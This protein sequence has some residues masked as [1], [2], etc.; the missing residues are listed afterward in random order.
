MLELLKSAVMHLQGMWRYR[1]LGMAVL[2]GITL[3]GAAAVMLLPST[4]KSEARIY[5]DSES[6]LRPLLSGLA[7]GTDVGSELSLV[8]RALISRPNLESVARKTD[9]YLRAQNEL[10]MEALLES[11]RRRTTIEGGGRESLYTIA[12]EDSDPVMAQ[13]IVQTF[14]TTFVEDTL[15]MNRTDSSNAQR[16]L[17]TQIAE[18]ERRLREAE[19]RLAEF[20]QKN[21][22]IM[23]ESG[24]DYYTRMQNASAELAAA[25]ERLRL[26]TS[27]RD[28]LLRQIEGEEP[29]FGLA[30]TPEQDR[31]AGGIDSRIAQHRR[32][33]DALLVQFTDKHPQVVA[34]RETIAQLEQQRDREQASER[35]RPVSS[36]AINALNVNPVYQSMKIALSS[37]EVEIASLRDEIA[38]KERDASRLRGL[39]NTIPEVEAQLSRLNRDYEVNR[40]Q[41]AALLQRLESARLSEN[42]EQSKQQVKFRIVEPAVV[43]L[44]PI[45]PNRPLFL[46]AV[47]MLALGGGAAVVFVLN[48]LNP[49]FSTRSALRAF[50]DLPVLGVVSSIPPDPATMRSE[51]RNTFLLSA[52]AAS[53]LLVFVLTLLFSGTIAGAVGAA[54]VGT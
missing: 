21:V 2:W 3:L 44:R 24:V 40:T 49:V 17:E 52:S 28:E 36:T 39:V 35:R 12:F 1:W 30:T 5:V 32:E 41:H 51:R 22:G 50:A 4:Y 16:F 14:V 48:Q 53:L 54:A 9:L 25:R 10:Q 47:L 46:V 34:L 45:G 43:P 18:Y 37:A 7:V 11:L 33:L 19:D 27:K 13:R 26:T 20:K 29:T 42:A 15:G 8:T 38:T 6:V 31:S 23:P